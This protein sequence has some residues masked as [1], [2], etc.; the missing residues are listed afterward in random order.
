MYP[1]IQTTCRHCGKQIA[2]TTD[3]LCC[4]CRYGK[5]DYREN[6]SD[7]DALTL[8]RRHDSKFLSKPAPNTL[9]GVCH[10]CGLE[11]KNC[12]CKEIKK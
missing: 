10:Q 8:M 2:A 7:F 1:A 4:S 5:L 3:A 9:T 12:L 11:V 6:K